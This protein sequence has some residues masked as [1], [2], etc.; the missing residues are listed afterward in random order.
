MRVFATLPASDMLPTKRAGTGLVA[1]LS[2]WE[3][4][5]IE[6]S[7]RIDSIQPEEDIP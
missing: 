4:R 1:G 7:L 5:G 6:D 2:G 3:A